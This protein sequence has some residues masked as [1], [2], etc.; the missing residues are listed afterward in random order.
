MAD[1]QELRDEIVSTIYPNGIGA[2][3]AASHQALLL[4]M[5][6]KIGNNAN[7]IERLNSGQLT[8]VSEEEQIAFPSENK[9]E[10]FFASNGDS[11]YHPST[12]FDLYYTQVDAECACR[13]ELGSYDADTISAI[14]VSDNLPALDIPYKSITAQEANKTG[15][16]AANKGQYIV[17]CVAKGQEAY[18]PQVWVEKRTEFNIV[19][20]IEKAAASAG[21]KYSIERTVYLTKLELFGEIEDTFEITEEQREYNR[22]TVR[23]AIDNEMPVSLNTGGQ[24]F[25][26]YTSGSSEARF[27][28]SY[29]DE[30]EIWSITIFINGNGDAEGAWKVIPMGATKEELT[31][32]QNEISAEVGKKQDTISDLET[33][34]SGAAKGATAIQSVKTINGQ[35]IIGEGDITIEADVD[36]SAFATKEELTTLQTEVINNEEVTAAA[37]NDLNA[38]IGAAADT[39]YVDNAIASAITSTLNTEV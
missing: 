39:A 27:I 37:I 30:T 38:R 17:F 20:E 35:S 11:E 6:D 26:P 32:L 16:F 15:V 12:Y 31:T 36:T 22:E 24:I 34:R 3:K 29:V 25:A 9:L 10:S 4:K 19:E 7:R 33:I 23:L 5:A 14:S 1:I 8:L 21:L 13:Y 2:I 28:A 18:V